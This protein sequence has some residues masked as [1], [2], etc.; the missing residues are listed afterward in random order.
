VR[1]VVTFLIGA[2]MGG[3]IWIRIGRH[4]ARALRSYHDLQATRQAMTGLARR[5]FDEWV[6][7]VKK[8]IVLAAVAAFVVA[9]TV[10]I[11]HN[12]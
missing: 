9:M 8:L 2:F 7:L 6:G 11:G 10:S 5:T 1:Y 3:P 12:R 4:H